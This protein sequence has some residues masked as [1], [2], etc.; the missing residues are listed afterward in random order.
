MCN[1]N[2]FEQYYSYLS[3]IIDHSSKKILEASTIRILGRPVPFLKNQPSPWDRLRLNCDTVARGLWSHCGAQLRTNCVASVH[4]CVTTLRMHT[5]DHTVPQEFSNHGR[6]ASNF[7]LTSKEMIV[8]FICEIKSDKRELT[9]HHLMSVIFW[10][11]L[12]WN[13]D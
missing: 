9:L 13:G 10:Q 8:R 2:P 5:V 3:L 7:S 11:I 1:M 12:W 6:L 4:I